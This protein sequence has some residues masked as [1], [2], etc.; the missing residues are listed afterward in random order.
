MIPCVATAM[1]ESSTFRKRRA[2]AGKV[3]ILDFGCAKS[4][5]DE[6]GISY[7][8]LLIGTPA[9]M[10]PEQLAGNAVD[11]RTD[12]FSLG[13]LLY[14]MAGGRPPF[15]GDNL[16]SVVRALALRGA[17]AVRALNPQV[18]QSTVRLDQ[19][20][21][22]RNLPTSDPPRHKRLWTSCRPL[23]KGFHLIE[24]ARGGAGAC[25]TESQAGRGH[26]KKVG[27][28]RSALASRFLPL[29]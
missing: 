8:G 13:C 29:V 14:R 3:K 12:L 16:L 7:P 11:P 9:Y 6:S 26:G 2:P 10:A 19:R 28:G 4:W 27:N 20:A 25:S 15:G 18:P 5:T 21:S 1:V 24:S 22:Y 17:S 23:S